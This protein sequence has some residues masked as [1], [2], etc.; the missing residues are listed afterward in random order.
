MYNDDDREVYAFYKQGEAFI[1]PL[2]D[3]NNY[4]MDR[5]TDTIGT[6]YLIYNKAIVAGTSD[7][8][9]FFKLEWD[10]ILERRKWNCYKT[11]MVAGTAYYTKGNVRI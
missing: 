9:S 2:N 3:A 11:I 4:I 1:V 6:I 5:M 10:E 7:C 8:T